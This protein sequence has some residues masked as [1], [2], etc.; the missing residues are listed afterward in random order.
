MNQMN[1]YKLHTAVEYIKTQPEFPF[2]VYD[3]EDDVQQVLAYFGLHPQ[4]DDEERNE[5]K[6][7][8]RELALASELAEIE[9]VVVSTGAATALCA[10][11]LM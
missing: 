9:R 1:R 4:L 3:V 8:L 11:P 10:A 7:D 6:R 5:L 2:D